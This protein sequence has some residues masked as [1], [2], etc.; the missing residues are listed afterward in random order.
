MDKPSK[1][2]V[3]RA[4]DNLTE[5]EISNIREWY[6]G[7]RKSIVATAFRSKLPSS[8]VAA[9]LKQHGLTR[10]STETA[11]GSYWHKLND[12]GIARHRAEFGD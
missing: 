3:A 6:C 7:Q 11:R 4:P 8:A 1:R 2:R 12:S 10:S 9:Y 5:H